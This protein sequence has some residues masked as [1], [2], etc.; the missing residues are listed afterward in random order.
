[1]RPRHRLLVLAVSVAG[2]FGPA[3]LEAGFVFSKVAG[4]N[5]A[6]PGGGGDFTS[7]KPP[8]IDGGSIA[9]KALGK[10]TD[11]IYLSSAGTLSAVA[12]TNTPV[13]GGKGTFTLFD[14][15]VSVSGSRVAF[16]AFARDQLE[17]IFIGTAGGKPAPVATTNTTA[18]G[19]GKKF[20]YF[21]FFSY[22]GDTAFTGGGGGVSGVFYTQAGLKLLPTPTPAS[23][24]TIGLSLTSPR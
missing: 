10:T 2:L 16:M 15:V 8:S 17:G 6:I 19:T 1:M 14:N 22:K 12:D 9:F 7:F 21:S 18:P 3:R 13:P 11:G 5:T 23:P 24:G 20:E 4:T